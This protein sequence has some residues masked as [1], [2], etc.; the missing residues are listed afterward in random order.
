MK[1][2]GV[3][4]ILVPLILVPLILIPLLS[5]SACAPAAPTEA[6]G[7]VS[8]LTLGDMTGAVAGL[9]APANIATDQL[10]DYYNQEMGGIHYTDP[11]T[12]KPMFAMLR[13]ILVD[14]RYDVARAVSAYRRYRDS[15]KLVS[16]ALVST[17]YGKALN[18]LFTKDKVVFWAPGD[19]E[20]QAR[21]S[22]GFTDGTCYEDSYG[23][24]LEWIDEV[25]WPKKGLA[26]PPVIGFIGWDSAYGREPLHGTVYTA[27]DV[28][29]GSLI[30]KLGFTLLPP[31]FFPVGT[32]DHT[33]YLSRLKGADYIFYGGVD[34]TPTRLIMDARKLGMVKE[35][36]FI[37][38]FW[39]NDKLIGVTTHPDALEGTL[40]V[41]FFLK[42][43]EAENSWYSGLWEWTGETGRVPDLGSWGAVLTYRA[44]EAIRLGLNEV[45][46]EAF[47]GDVFR[48]QLEGMTGD[49]GIFRGKDGTWPAISPMGPCTFS[50]T[51]HTAST[52]VKLY[53]V[54]NGK[55]VPE[56]DWVECPDTVA[57][58]E[59]E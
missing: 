12:G 7:E 34:P 40:N 27:P 58:Y 52:V 45:G 36:Q 21:L 56:T 31:E 54:T 42:G 14:T 53:R 3:W 26:R 49:D 43:E 39:S 32:L 10:A 57:M 13:H 59:W 30:D 29:E 22:W 19:G 25:D 55:L 24:A 4:Q 15:P 28:V 11:E 37:G 6:V 48:E 16:C 9:A 23:M 35:T 20:W 5:T 44:F 8:M 41:S 51:R 47:D 17:P 18:P 38:D 33:P 1:K 2:R 46:Y 50:P